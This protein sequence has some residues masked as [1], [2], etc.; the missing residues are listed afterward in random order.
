MTRALEGQAVKAR[1]A[2]EVSNFKLRA[3]PF[4]RLRRRRQ[5]GHELALAKRREEEAL[6]LLSLAKDDEQ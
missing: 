6:R 1:L 5:I 3:Q 4:W 2:A